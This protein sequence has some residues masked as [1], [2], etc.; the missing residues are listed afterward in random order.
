[1]QKMF[2]RFVALG[3][4]AAL[5]VSNV[6]AQTITRIWP[7]N[8]ADSAVSQFADT[9]R[10]FLSTT[11]APNP[12]AGFTGWVSKPIACADPSKL[13]SA[14]WMWN[15]LASGIGGAYYGT[16][17]NPIISES[18]AN[19]AAVFNSDMYDTRGV[20]GAFGSGRAPSPQEA[21]LISPVINAAGYTD[22]TVQF[23]QY[24]RNFDSE[25]FLS[26]STDG[27]TT[28]SARVAFNAEIAPNAASANTSAAA[29]T[30]RVTLF[31]SV[32]SPN[33]RVKFIWSGDFYY[34]ILDD[35]KLVD[36]KVRD[37][38]I[39]TNFVA[40]PPSLYTPREQMENIYF[41]TDVSNAGTRA[42]TNTKVEVKVFDPSNVLKY[43]AVT[44]AG[45][46][47][48]SFAAATT[49]ENVIVPGSFPSIGLPL[50]RYTGYYRV[51]GDSTDNIPANDT[52]K[53]SFWVTDTAAARSVVIAGVGQSNYAKENGSISTTRPANSGWVANEAHSWRVG[54]YYRIKLG[55]QSQGRGTVTSMI[56]RLNAKAAAGTPLQ[57]SLYKWI[58]ANADG[59]VNASER[60]LVALG[61]TL[62]PANNINGNTWF[63]FPIRDNNTGDAFTPEDNTDYL[64]VI[65]WNAP[66]STAGCLADS[67]YLYAGFSSGL[68]NYGAMRFV[69]DSM[70]APRYSIILGKTL[71]DDWRTAGFTN[72]S[73]V[74]VVRLNV[75]S[76]NINN[77]EIL[78]GSY[79][80]VVA[81]NPV[82]GDHA[83]VNIEMPKQQDVAIRV[84]SMDGRIIAEQ[85]Q[86]NMSQN[87]QVMIDISNYTSGTY[88]VQLLTAD[89]VVT[90]RFVVS[91]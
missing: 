81:P 9:T 8:A 90:K 24:Y 28:W 85:V 4:A 84:Y 89:G 42:Q 55:A 44:T 22:I 72:Q 36:Y 86:D 59:V 60:T 15:R 46:Y 32:G 12:A 51:F 91:K 2:T 40:I 41:L 6:H 23:N 62:V 17:V 38:Q 27:G 66:Q 83:M 3:F 71:T 5:T 65:E 37:L 18:P 10:I 76:F 47:P 29:S 75:L 68:Y 69:T 20:A 50:G 53:F 11:A 34:W 64:A 19:G 74:P 13:D 52:F 16:A 61:D 79:K 73:L 54:N 43:S 63:R 49:V 14:Q 39:N 7:L 67:C 87:Q 35:V 57:A 30:K 1:M 21:E 58:D 26:Y 77:K 25:C 56:A 88:M 45:Q 48:T 80:V 78:D 70:Q 31:G 82:T 33:F